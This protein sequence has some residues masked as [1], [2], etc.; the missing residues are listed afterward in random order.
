[1]RISVAMVKIEVIN[2]EFVLFVYGNCVLSEVSLSIQLDFI[3]YI[4]VPFHQSSINGK[5]AHFY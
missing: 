4:A 1:M 2:P 5:V 3:S